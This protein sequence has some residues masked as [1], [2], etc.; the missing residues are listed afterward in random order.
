MM[1]QIFLVI[2]FALCGSQL[3]AQ[4]APKKVV[5]NTPVFAV[6]FDFEAG[7]AAAPEAF[8]TASEERTSL[9]A[10]R[11]KLTAEQRKPI[12]D[13]NSAFLQKVQGLDAQ[14]RLKL[15]E[16]ILQQIAAHMTG[17][18]RRYLILDY[19]LWRKTH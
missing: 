5:D 17:R 16:E 15:R 9:M 4:N 6:D 18:Q 2:T 19:E 14:A 11:Y 3:F 10:T 13:L 1:K 7:E 12:L 8:A